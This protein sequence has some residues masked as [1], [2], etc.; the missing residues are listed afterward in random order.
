M[1][2]ALAAP[3]AIASLVAKAQTVIDPDAV[4]DSLV[5]TA[6]GTNEAIVVAGS[7]GE[8]GDGRAYVEHQLPSPGYSSDVQDQFTIYSEVAVLGRT[9]AAARTRGYEIVAGWGQAIAADPTLGDSV[10]QAWISNVGCTA[11]QAGRG[12]RVVLLVAVTCEVFTGP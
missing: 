8:T 12:A 1:T 9:V 10:M 7:S 3:N 6:S 5:V 4:L 11:E 2:W